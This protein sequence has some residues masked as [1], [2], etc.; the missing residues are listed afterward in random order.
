MA[1]AFCPNTFDPASDTNCARLA[2]TTAG[3]TVAANAASNAPTVTR[4]W[5]AAC[6][7]WVAAVPSHATYAAAA[8]LI[9]AD[10][11]PCHHPP[12]RPDVTDPNEAAAERSSAANPSQAATAANIEP[13]PT[14]LTPAAN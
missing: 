3:C 5:A 12:D 1:E 6:S 11:G 9:A 8:S 4:A 10:D 14:P 2:A 13:D 7:A